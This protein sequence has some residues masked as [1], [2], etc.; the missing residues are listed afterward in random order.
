MSSWEEIADQ[1]AE[2]VDA[3]N[4]GLEHE[5]WQKL[6]ELHW[7]PPAVPDISPTDVEENRLRMLL[8]D[9][10][11]LVGHINDRTVSLAD[12]REE[13]ERKRKAARAYL[14]GNFPPD[15]A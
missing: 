12:K 13:I 15:A 10:N 9:S 3:I 2:T 8:E 6:S 5:D 4:D 1:V 14:T 7:E 11:R